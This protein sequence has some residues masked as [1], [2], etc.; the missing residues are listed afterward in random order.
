MI[1]RKLRLEKGWSQEQLAEICD[2]SVRTIQRIESGQTPSL[3]TLKA[4][5]SVF[6][7]EVTALSREDVMSGQSMSAEEERAVISVRDLKGFYTHLVI[8]GVVISGLLALNLVR[9][10]NHFWAMW[11]AIGWGVGVVFHG[12]NVFEAFSLFGADWEKRQL[13]KRLK[14]DA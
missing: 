11:P 13:N 9:P 4:L 8:Y 2:L 6:E 1:I 3:E 10:T 5:A 14:R 7:T 12:L